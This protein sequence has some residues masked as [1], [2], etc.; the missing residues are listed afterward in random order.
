MP[1]EMAPQEIAE[2]LLYLDSHI[3]SDE[4]VRVLSAA[5]S[6]VRKVANGELVEAVHAH[7]TK[8]DDD[9]FHGIQCSRC[10]EKLVT[11]N[12]PKVCPGCGAHMDGDGD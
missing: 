1:N 11:K 4:D 5:A 3:E 2:K 10:G 8:W 6:I 12:S 7:W 9:W